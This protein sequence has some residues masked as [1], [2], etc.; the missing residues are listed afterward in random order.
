MSLLYGIF[1][2]FFFFRLTWY[3]YS[4]ARTTDEQAT[5]L[6]IFL[7]HSKIITNKQKNKKKK[8][9]YLINMEMIW[10]RLGDDDHTAAYF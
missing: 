9:N 2:L 7:I 6:F 10:F 8:R 5:K 4:T 3:S 1:V